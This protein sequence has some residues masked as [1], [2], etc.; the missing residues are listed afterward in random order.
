MSGRDAAQQLEG[1]GF[2]P[3]LGKL[4]MP[5]VWVPALPHDNLWHQRA[6]GAQFK[7]SN[8]RGKETLRWN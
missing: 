7:G 5:Q 6:G 3:W 4:L 2:N 8:T 1:C